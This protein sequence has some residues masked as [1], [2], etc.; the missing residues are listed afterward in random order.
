[1][2]EGTVA[3]LKALGCDSS[4]AMWYSTWGKSVQTAQLLGDGLGIV[5]EERH[6]EYSFLDARG[7]GQFEGTPL[8]RAAQDLHALDARSS[9][10]GP[11][12]TNDGTGAE[13]AK[14]L[15]IR[16]LQMIS[17][18]ETLAEGRDVVVVA[19]DSDLLSVWQAAI[20]GAPLEGH[21]AFALAPGEARQLEYEIGYGPQK[22]HRAL[23]ASGSSLAQRM[24]DAKQIAAAGS[25]AKAEAAANY[26]DATAAT[27]APTT[28]TKKETTAAKETMAR[29]Q[30]AAE[31]AA[32][33]ERLQDSREGLEDEEEAA[34]ATELAEAKVARDKRQAAAAAA[35]KKQK[36]AA[37][38][39]RRVRQEAQA[40]KAATAAAALA[41]KNAAVAAA[42]AGEAGANALGELAKEY[43]VGAVIAAWGA[44]QATAGARKRSDGDS[45][46]IS[47]ARPAPPSSN[48]A[49]NA[50]GG[51]GATLLEVEGEEE[52][53]AV[54]VARDAAAEA[55]AFSAQ[56]ALR[57]QNALAAAISAVEDSESVEKT[58][59]KLGDDEVAEQ[60]QAALFAGGGAEG[61]SEK[62]E[63]RTE[64]ETAADALADLEFDDAS[65]LSAID[66]IK[67][68]EA[69]SEA[70]AA[71]YLSSGEKA[72]GAA[73]QQ[74]SQWAIGDDSSDGVD[75]DRD[76]ATAAAA[77][78]AA[79]QDWAED[80][81]ARQREGTD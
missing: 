75:E 30:E 56:T 45:D 70:A 22:G 40:A 47:F 38:A 79:V 15:S 68:S 21:A 61:S 66:E 65:W 8:A 36:E 16:V 42:S 64:E 24:A 31:Q 59:K 32:L 17:I 67:L 51:A 76:L 33:S 77:A 9:R 26:A 25:K 69:I 60:W 46:R 39:E 20:A 55:A 50:D 78:A 37:A 18:M 49:A 71:D 48:S 11:P 29:K 1:M 72:P 28:G 62:Q 13:S 6:P 3:A 74:W 14:D 7:M 52:D 80:N 2:S 44:I 57:T 23:A 34:L 10:V 4:A 73:P 27:S 35:R 41:D 53:P 12:P 43:P 5:A 54:A 81:T 63:G 19:A 58:L